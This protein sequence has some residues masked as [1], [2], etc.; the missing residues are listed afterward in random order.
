MLFSRSLP[1]AASIVVNALMSAPAQNSIGLA[2]AITS[3][4]MFPAERTASHSRRSACTISGAIEFAGGRSSQA[5]AI[6]ATRLELDR[7]LLPASVRPGVGEEP[8]AGLDARGDPARPAAGGSRAARSAR[9]TPRRRARAAASTSSSP[10]WS[11][12]AKGGG[13]I[14]APA[15]IPRSMSFI[16]ATPSSSTRQAST[17]AL[18]VKRS[19]RAAVSSS[20]SVLIEALPGL[21]PELALGYQLAASP[22]ARRTTRRTRRAGARPRAAPCRARVGRPG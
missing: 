4:R 15:I 17:S 8:L 21:R 1:A 13:M 2:E 14:P 22:R 19:I 10:T 9:P 3:A 6:V 7:T 12:R 5:I 20:A 16:D 11:A 18:S